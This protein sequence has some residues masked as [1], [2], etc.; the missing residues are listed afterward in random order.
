MASTFHTYSDFLHSGDR[1]AATEWP[2]LFSTTEAVKATL[3]YDSTVIILRAVSAEGYSSG[4]A[5]GGL[6]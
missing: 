1:L 4:L 6:G 2:H 5:P 3:R